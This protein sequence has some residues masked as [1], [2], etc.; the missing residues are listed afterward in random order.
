MSSP[1]VNSGYVVT[2]YSPSSHPGVLKVDHSS[3]ERKWPLHGH[4][5]ALGFTQIFIAVTQI[6]LGIIL[7]AAFQQREGSSIESGVIFWAP[8]LFIISGMLSV[9]VENKTNDSLIK[10]TLAMN[11]V[12]CI[13]AG[14]GIIIYC[15]DLNF[16]FWIAICQDAPIECSHYEKSDLKTQWIVSLLLL[17][18]SLVELGIAIATSA[19]G[20]MTTCHCSRCCNGPQP[21]IIVQSGPAHDAVIHMAPTAA[22]S[23]PQVP[24]PQQFPAVEPSSYPMQAD[25]LPFNMEPG[26]YPEVK[27]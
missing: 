25:V 27:P 4:P 21:M 6:S 19:F 10:A 8:M 3:D 16:Y 5:K 24:M 17:A 7:C 15:I 23:T 1:A 2:Q 18:L 9:T 12:S 26:H 11:I 22:T 14:V 13:A 20:C